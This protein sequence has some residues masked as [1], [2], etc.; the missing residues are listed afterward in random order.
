MSD[1]LIMND[2]H[3]GVARVT[4]TTPTSASALKEYLQDEFKVT[5]HEHLDKDLVILGDLLDGFTIEGRELV[6]VYFTFA[7]WLLASG[8]TL[9][10][11][12]GNHDY[13]AKGDK[14]SSFHFLGQILSAQFGNRVVVYEPEFS[15]IS[16]GLY[17]V[18]H[19]LNQDLFELELAKALEAESGDLLLHCNVMN[20]FA[21]KADHSLNLT[22]S[23]AERLTAKHRLI[24]AH[25]HQRRKVPMGFGIHILGNQFPSS[26][27]D[28]LDIAGQRGMK[29][30]HTLDE[31]QILDIVPTW[32]ANE[33]IGFRQ[34][35]WQELGSVSDR[36]F[37]RVTGHATAEQAAE[38]ITAIAKFRSK[39]QAFVV[40]NAVVVEGVNNMG[41]LT[42]SSLEAI[43]SFNVLGALMELLEPAERKVIEEILK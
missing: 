4:G 6:E 41:A 25:E 23:W 38:V 39:S 34:V 7:S 1:F 15:T 43:Q 18:P 30:A 42:E 5:I 16:E 40:T 36:G 24:V 3:L 35:D 17:T 32:S 19:C 37:I 26:V 14:L 31:Q 10:L 33:D 11:I 29:F 12:P 2:L 22:E 8:R 20:P 27:A 28:C 9:H 13:S 21:D